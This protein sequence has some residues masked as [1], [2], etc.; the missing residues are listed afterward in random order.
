[1][2]T[3]SPV[4][5][6]FGEVLDGSAHAPGD[7][8]QILRADGGT[9]LPPSSLGDPDPENTLIEETAV[10]NL[11][12]ASMSQPGLFGLSMTGTKR[13]SNGQQIFVRV[14]NAP[15]L[16]DASFY[17]DSSLFTINGNQEF[18][19]DITAADTPLDANDDDED[20]LHN[21]YEKSLG[22]E[23]N[24]PDSDGDGFIDGHEFAAGTDAL[25][26]GS[27][28]AIRS[29]TPEPGGVRISWDTVPD[30]KY[31]LQY[32]PDPLSGPPSYTAK[33]PVLTATTNILD[34]LVTDGLPDTRGHY[35][36]KV[37]TP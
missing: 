37:V 14:F 4:V 16:E 10:G 21:S 17:G 2:A 28:L 5:N 19:V 11:A 20:G 18:V 36:V 12:P 13:P 26:S 32:S 30:I 27:F 35:R 9:A 8:V 15:T 31:Q 33:S 7:L 25:N 23:K 22:T 1:M 34:V 6:E 24:N 29:M 3:L